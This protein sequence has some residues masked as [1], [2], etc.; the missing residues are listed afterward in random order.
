MF[1]RGNQKKSLFCLLSETQSVKD[2][3]LNAGVLH[4]ESPDTSEAWALDARQ[5][6]K[7][8]AT[9]EYIQFV[10][11]THYKPIKIYSRLESS[12]AAPSVI[13]ALEE[14]KEMTFIDQGRNK[15]GRLI[16]IGVAL[17]ALTL[18]LCIVVLKAI[19]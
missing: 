8:K 6:V 7:D 2:I 12:V 9:D 19:S 11:N 3:R 13:A 15:D 14:D 4:A 16:W 5:Q 18:I 17:A 10:A 1:G